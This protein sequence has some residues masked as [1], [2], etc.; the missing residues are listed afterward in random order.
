MN[1]ATALRAKRIVV[2]IADARASSDAS[3]ELVTHALGSCVGVTMYDPIAKVAG[4]LHAMLPDAA[5]SPQKALRNPP[6]FV[7]SGLPYLLQLCE[8][9]GA[10]S[11]RLIIKVA[12]AAHV[13]SSKTGADYFQIGD[14]NVVA[15]R[16]VLW[17]AGLL[18]K[19]SD[20]GGNLSRTLSMSVGTGDVTLSGEFGVR[21]L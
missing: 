8:G 3:D 2:G 16:R 17:K 19:T 5:T 7:E 21:K 9:L 4:L 13:T 14:R 20:V 6:M 11:S 18:L 10:L 15:V 1:A 12:G